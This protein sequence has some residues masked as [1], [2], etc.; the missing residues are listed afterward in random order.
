MNSRSVL[1]LAGIVLLVVVLVLLFPA[2]L[3]F[4]EA[5]AGE[6]RF[7]WWVILVVALAIWLIFWG[8]G[9]KEK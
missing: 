7:F 3:E 6:L 9:K 4:I 5:F 8:F 2:L 1:F